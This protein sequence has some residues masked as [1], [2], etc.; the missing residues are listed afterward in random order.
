MTGNSA[1]VP[2]VAPGASGEVCRLTICG[3]DSQVELAVPAHV[4]IADLMPTLLGQLDPALATTG[5]GHD[6]WVLQRLGEAPLEEDQGTAAAGI[7]DGDVLYLRPRSDQLPVADFDDLV[8]GV[9][10]GLS[11]RVD[12]W[13]PA[14]TRR[15]CMLTA[16]LCGLLAVLIAT[17]GATGT[18]IAVVAGSVSIVLL[19]SALVLAKLLDD[20]GSGLTLA[21]LGVVAAAVAGLAM[22]GADAAPNWFGGPS[23]IAAGTSVALAAAL[24]RASLGLAG[25]WFLAVAC[26]GVLLAL[27]GLVAVLVGLGGPATAAIAVPVLAASTRA[28]PQLA[29]W[30]G[31]L[32]AEPVPTTPDQFQENLDPLPSKDVLDRAGLADA[33]L[34]ALLAVLGALFTGALLVLASA[35]RW[36][37]LTLVGLATTLLLL[38]A[39]ELVA[40]W[41]RVAMLA[42]AVVAIVA[43][44]LGWAAGLPLLGQVCVLF[45]LLGLA[46]L[47]VA[48]AEL[49]PGRR[50]VPRWGRWGDLLQGGCA[51]AVLSIVL[52]VTGFYGW[53]ASWL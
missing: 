42:P 26:G 8:D 40:I 9:H 10:S 23:V 27:A 16:T 47:A 35:P 25:A 46:G 51:L 29:A 39:R 49:L 12:R 28:A 38:Q 3:P 32:A 36:D 14:L 7:Y 48:G 24:A 45:G 52:S 4:P 43:V 18:V 6:G 34:T 50:L 44:V 22:P 53:A 5:L 17:F 41:H 2:A 19:S 11:G 30:V 33:H 13:R 37:S 15:A 20:N 31:G 21:G 1:P